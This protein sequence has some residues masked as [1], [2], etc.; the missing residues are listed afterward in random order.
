MQ[1]ESWWK[2]TE[3]QLR[4]LLK[5]DF[6]YLRDCG[7]TD[8]GLLATFAICERI[9][10]KKFAI[11]V[12][13]NEI[14]TLRD[15]EVRDLLQRRI[16]DVMNN[17]REL[18]TKSELGVRDVLCSCRGCNWGASVKPEAVQETFHSHRCED[19]PIRKVG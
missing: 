8:H 2:H 15:D 19:F 14:K 4:D 13:V 9:G 6:K 12:D 5:T 17:K 18:V 7:S 1:D 16:H 11:S 3:T 10:D